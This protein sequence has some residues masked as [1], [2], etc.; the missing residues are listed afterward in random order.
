QKERKVSQE[1][2]RFLNRPEDTKS[3]IMP[4]LSIIVLIMVKKIFPVICFLF[5]APYTSA[6][7]RGTVEEGNR[8]FEKGKYAEALNKYQDARIDEPENN[9]LHFNTGNTLY[10]ISKYEEASREY[11][12]AVNSS[13]LSI[14]GK[15][16]YNLGNC[17]YKLGRLPEAI[18][19]YKKSLDIDPSDQ[20][21]KYNLQFVQQKL[22]EQQQQ[23]QQCQ[24]NKNKQEKG[25]KG[26]QK[27]DDWSD[28]KPNAGKEGEKKEGEEEKE[29]QVE[30]RR[31][32]KGGEKEEEAREAKEGKMSKEDAQRLIEAFKD[33]EREAQIKRKL[34]MKPPSPG[35]TEEDW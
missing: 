16:Y 31:E 5:L 33:K 6:S 28:T 21:A 32:K 26:D 11:S 2:G 34:M 30:E 24:N 9:R 22:N 35:K 4:V 29:K 3:Q 25:E 17:A 15:S 23:Q 13:D 14:Q 20:D 12:R 18:T 1:N 7:V 8:L 10:K 19:Y 27:K